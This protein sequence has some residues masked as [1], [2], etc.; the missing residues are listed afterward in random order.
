MG[1]ELLNTTIPIFNCIDNLCFCVL[2]IEDFQ[3]A[4]EFSILSCPELDLKGLDLLLV[5]V[6]GGLKSLNDHNNICYTFLSI[7]LPDE[8]SISLNLLFSNL[9]AIPLRIVVSLRIRDYLRS[10]DR[11]C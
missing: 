4:F 8:G 9:I 6:N 3:A 10:D 7:G 11:I 5:G 1:L 2:Q